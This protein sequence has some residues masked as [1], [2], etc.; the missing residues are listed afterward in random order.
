M[1]YASRSAR[2][3][4]FD[5]QRPGLSTHGTPP[6]QQNAFAVRGAGGVLQSEEINGSAA[7]AGAEDFGELLLVAARLGV[8]SQLTLNRCCSDFG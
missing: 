2:S 7:Q 1:F 6:D 4:R 5:Q 3:P 8:L